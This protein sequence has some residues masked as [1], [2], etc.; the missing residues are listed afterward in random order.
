MWYF[1]CTHYPLIKEEIKLVLGDE[2]TFF[3][4]APNLA[5]HLREVLEENN[6]KEIQ[7]GTVEFIDS[8]NS[9]SKKER[10]YNILES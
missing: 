2:I 4:G 9:E 1:G 7:E 3:N 5:K 10:F 6:L 8:N